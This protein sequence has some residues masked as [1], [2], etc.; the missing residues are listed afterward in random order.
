MTLD[1]AARSGLEANA[2]V[3]RNTDGKELSRQLSWRKRKSAPG[4]DILL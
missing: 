4:S 3:K 2:Y 1:K